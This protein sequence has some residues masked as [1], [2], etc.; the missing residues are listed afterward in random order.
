MGLDT[1][2][3]VMQFEEEFDAAGGALQLFCSLSLYSGRGLGRGCIWS[4]HKSAPSPLPS[5]WVQG[6]GGNALN[7]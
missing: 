3:L 6:E 4:R 2:E 5:P 7:K 1:V